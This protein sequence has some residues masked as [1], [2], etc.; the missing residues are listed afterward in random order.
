M[1]PTP[2]ERMA[3]LLTRTQAADLLGI[4]PRKLYNLARA[5]VVSEVR[6]GRAV[7][8]DQADLEVLVAVLKEVGHG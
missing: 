6:I 5:G 1:T 4:S 7:R 3:P 8:Y 2:R